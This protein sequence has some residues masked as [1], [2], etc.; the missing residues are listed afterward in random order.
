MKGTSVNGLNELP[1][2]PKVVGNLEA[3]EV[4]RCWI[5]DGGLQLSVAPL[6]FSKNAE[7]WGLLLSD[8]ARHIAQSFEQE[9]VHSYDETRQR[10]RAQFD[11]EWAMPTGDAVTSDLKK[12]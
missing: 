8:V 1:P 10:I 11:I 2:P 4:L 3:N 6:V 12:Q 7:T 9:G 5:V